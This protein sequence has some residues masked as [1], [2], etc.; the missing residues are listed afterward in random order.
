MSGVLVSREDW[1]RILSMADSL[2]QIIEWQD[3]WD[4][5]RSAQKY[6]GQ[7][8]TQGRE[9][10][11]ALEWNDPTS[12]AIALSTPAPAGAVAGG[13]E[14]RKAALWDALMGSQRLR[15][16]GWADPTPEGYAHF[17]LEAWTVYPGHDFSADN[18]RAREVITAYAAALQPERTP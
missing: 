5:S 1:E 7:A 6:F 13:E 18:A 14:E 3:N 17:G 10:L 16:L 9:A 2:R 11:C 8:I 15:L 4:G 12:L